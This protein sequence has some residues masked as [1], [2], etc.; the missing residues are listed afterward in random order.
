LPLTSNIDNCTEDDILV[1]QD[2]YNN[3]F[4]DSVIKVHHVQT[5]DKSRFI[6]RIGKIE[7][8]TMK[9]VKEYLREH[10]DL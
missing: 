1:A 3:L 7:E 10:F 5:F 8:G 2:H 6:K 4:A 9:I